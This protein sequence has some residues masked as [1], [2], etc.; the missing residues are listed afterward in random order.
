M[1]AVTAT[2]T[3]ATV[4]RGL[5]RVCKQWRGM[6]GCIIELWNMEE[7]CRL[8]NE[9][10]WEWEGRRK[11]ESLMPN[12]GSDDHGNLRANYSIKD[13]MNEVKMIAM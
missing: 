12:D 9:E 11:I 7:Y 1:T 13:T 5:G 6:A 3:V 2:G 10:G 8:R 4:M